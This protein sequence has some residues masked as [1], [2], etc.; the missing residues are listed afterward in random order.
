[1]IRKYN[2]KRKK[3][4]TTEMFSITVD[5]SDSGYFVVVDSIDF[6]KLDLGPDNEIFLKVWT[7]NSLKKYIYLGTVSEPELNPE[8]EFRSLPFV[9]E[10]ITKHL[11]AE[12]F[13]AN[14]VNAYIKKS[15][16]SKFI[17][18]NFRI[19]K[20]EGSLLPVKYE[21]IGQLPWTIEYAAGNEM[22]VLNLNINLKAYEFIDHLRGKGRLLQSMIVYPAVKEVLRNIIIENECSKPEDAE[23]EWCASWLE[24]MQSIY[25]ESIP[26]FERNNFD[27]VE[28]WI[29]SATGNLSEVG[30]FIAGIKDEILNLR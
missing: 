6:K 2:Y 10:N 24:F 21:D 16:S 14:P 27:D 1:M 19:L 13:V 9:R 25:S 23:H 26:Q 3:Q 4:I 17:L 28:N 11:M 15:T 7:A 8:E 29:L 20:N 12:L 22:P 18:K 30:G 5:K